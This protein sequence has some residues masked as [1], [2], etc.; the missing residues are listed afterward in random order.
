M[1]S[2]QAA[3]IS[4]GQVLLMD[5]AHANEMLPQRTVL[6]LGQHR[7]S[8]AL[9]GPW[10]VV[11]GVEGIAKRVVQCGLA[12]E[13]RR[14]GGRRSWRCSAGS[15]GQGRTRPV[16]GPS[17]VRRAIASR[18]HLA[19]SIGRPGEVRWQEPTLDSTF[20]SS[21]RRVSCSRLADTEADLC[22]GGFRR[23][24]EHWN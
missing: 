5:L 24:Q 11:A 10:A 14:G 23:R 6:G 7:T 9:L 1:V 20:L 8:V 4:I 12:A 19:S 17:R 15:C 3:A 22:L 2:G 16:G 13:G 21:V 18:S